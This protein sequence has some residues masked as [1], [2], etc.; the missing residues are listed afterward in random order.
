MPR[1]T[2]LLLWGVVS[3]SFGLGLLIAL[4]VFRIAL[5]SGWYPMLAA[6]SVLSVL[7]IL[8]IAFGFKNERTQQ[9][10]VAR[11]SSDRHTA[12][13]SLERQLEDYRKLEG[14]LQ[15]AR[16]ATEAAM[17]A[18]GEFL[19]TMSHEVRTPLN[20]ILPMLDILL[21]A[22]LS[23][24]HHDL[25]RTAYSSARQMLRVVDDILDYSKLEANKV[26]LE[27]T[28]FN[29]REVVESVIRLMQRPAES[30]GLPLNLHIDQSVRLA[31]RGDPTRLRQVLTNLL[32]NAVKFTE[33]GK[34]TVNVKRVAETKQH[35]RIRF[36]V[37]DT[38]IGIS[39]TQRAS[40]FTAF[41]Q[42]DAS[43]TRL[44][45][46]TGLGLVICRRIVDL[47][48]GE[49]GVDPDQ[50]TGSMFWFEIPLLKAIGDLPVV[51]VDLD[52]ASIML[53]ATDPTLR[54]RIQFN[55][56]EWGTSLT[57]AESM[58]EALQK[59]RFAAERA[60]RVFDILI[61]DTSSGIDVAM[62]SR[63]L[64]R[65][66][67][68]R[69][70]RLLL[71]HGTQSAQL[72][73]NEQRTILS[74]MRSVTSAELRRTVLQLLSPNA[75]SVPEKPTT[76][77]V[78]T[79]IELA[80]P[81]VANAMSTSS[82]K[83]KVLIV[84]DNPVNLLVAQKLV[85]LIGFHCESVGDGQRALERLSMGGI[86]VVLM[87]CQMPVKDGYT[88]T[89]EWRA[90][91]AASQ[92]PRLPII[93]MTANAMAGDRQKCLDA[94]MD[95]YIAKPV[96]RRQLEAALTR[97]LQLGDSQRIVAAMQPAAVDQ[98]AAT[99][100]GTVQAGSP[101]ARSSAQVEM[102]NPAV[103]DQNIH[104]VIDANTIGEL[105]DVMG[106]DYLELIKVF[107]EDAPMHISKLEEAVAS[108]DLSRMVGPA[109]TLKSSSANLGALN[110]SNC[111]KRIELGARQG[112][113][114]KPAVA[115]AVLESEFKRVKQ[116]LESLR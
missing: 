45:G 46:G 107:L 38:G 34:I 17:M 69:D 76:H 93:A 47:M 5:I 80:T 115:V 99:T 20:G 25:V 102:K 84:E 104:P 55:A 30:K 91:E 77:S 61:V 33:R 79:K 103:I 109:H 4:A 12:I 18:K 88:A 112:V 29:L 23:H 97:W 100:P 75:D 21:S 59:L 85:N 71:L 81:A 1:L 113:L 26:E 54:E 9:T 89:S 43:T 7:G 90:H 105:K 92:S 64:A 24:E 65:S 48:Q 41:M 68:L 32:S 87:D 37:I 95:D 63:S 86:D 96:D 16:R 73:A 98:I 42:A 2:G 58:P 6:G 94:G 40:L 35:H 67:E 106:E 50:S 51:R 70:L 82:R 11:R 74:V 10:H 62:L 8:G 111:A 39:E 53:L 14:S 72:P 116:A 101:S 57:L 3:L 27:I 19:A 108:G 15:E 52:T 49:I 56:R 22:N 83:S 60:D 110:L 66:S 36:E 28:G 44:Y 78:Q 13:V 31:V 114:P